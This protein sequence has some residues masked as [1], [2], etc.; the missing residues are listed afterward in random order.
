MPFFAAVNEVFEISVQLATQDDFPCA[1]ATLVKVDGSSYRRAGARRLVLPDRAAIGA[2]SG[3]CLEQDIDAHAV[4]LI[5]S[6]NNY[7]LITYDTSSE[8]DVLWGTGTGC[9]GVVH[10]LIEK[11]EACPPWARVV[12]AHKNERRATALEVVWDEPS[13]SANTIGTRIERETSRDPSRVLGQLILPPLRVVIFGAGDD[14]PALHQLA[15]QLG[16]ETIIFDPRARFADAHRFPG[17]TSVACAPAESAAQRV[18]WDD[19]TVAVIMTHHYRFDLPLLQ[20][21]LPLRLPYLGLLGPRQRGQRLLADA[22]FPPDCES[23]H[24]PVG[25][26]LGGEGAPAVALAIVSEIQAHLHQ[27]SGRPL[28]ERDH[29][30][31]GS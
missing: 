9:H 17:A 23:L 1:L 16:W 25:L 3:G 22:G 12:Q 30:I 31:H 21:L 4:E 5:S 29:P 28:A 8:N 27:R 26:D 24:Y 6:S 19:Q 7:K 14:A 13:S 2:I 15:I 10:V 18:H 20:T 11:L